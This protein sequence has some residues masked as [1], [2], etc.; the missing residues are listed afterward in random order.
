MGAF[1]PNAPG[2]QVGAG[3]T[4]RAA[5]SGTALMRGGSIHTAPKACY[6]LQPWPGTSIQ[7]SYPPAP[8]SAK[9][10]C[11]IAV[12]CLSPIAPALAA[13]GPEAMVLRL[14]FDDCLDWVRDGTVPFQDLPQRSSMDDVLA[15]ELKAAAAKIEG[16]AFLKIDLLST[17]YSGIWI[18]APTY[19]SCFV[20]GATIANAA[21]DWPGRP[22][23]KENLLNTRPGFFERADQ[24]AT[25]E[26]FRSTGIPGMGVWLSAVP[27]PVPDG[28]DASISVEIEFLDDS[29]E[30]NHGGN[31]NSL[32]VTGP[33]PPG[34]G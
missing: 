11:A 20:R 14:A 31:F 32:S 3:E 2:R 15:G 24:R 13:E 25:R 4:A 7:M 10:L 19:R 27:F 34:Q 5:P 21:S 23:F 29:P 26:G 28:T 12:L 9:L 17:R 6:A 1:T 18:D 30:Y 8:R 33:K 22:A 16:F